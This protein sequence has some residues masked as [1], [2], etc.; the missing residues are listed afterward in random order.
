MPV[1]P[2]LAALLLA[3]PVVLHAQQPRL[4]RLIERG[5]HPAIRWGDFSEVQSEARTLYRDNGWQPLWVARGRPTRSARALLDALTTAGDRGLRPEDYDASQLTAL[6]ATLERG[7]ADAEQE[8]RFDAALSI[9]TLRL[10]RA[11]ALGRIPPREAN[12]R[13]STP[14]KPLDAVAT[15]REL[16]GSLDAGPILTALEPAWPQYLELKRAL[17]RYRALVRDSLSWR[18]PRPPTSGLREG[19][20]YAGA[21][22]LRRLLAALG[23]LAPEAAAPRGNDSTFSSE[24]ADG[25]RRFQVRQGG[26]AHV[27]GLLHEASWRLLSSQFSRRIRQMELALERWRWLPRELAAA[28]VPLLVNL[29]A[30]RLHYGAPAAEWLPVSMRV[31]LGSGFES[32][33]PVHAEILSTLLL[34]PP[35]RALGAVLFPTSGSPRLYLHGSTPAESYEEAAGCIRVA[36]AELLTAILLRGRADWPLERIRAALAGS[37]AMFVRLRQRVVVLVVYGTAVARENGQVFF[38]EDRFGLDRRLE[39]QLTRGYPYQ[40]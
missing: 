18:L 32:A 35:D 6:A 20:R 17:S 27:D 21:A 13:F 3:V 38:S 26:G 33:Q 12:V 16:R 4:Q 2:I 28:G 5:R 39:Q 22:R 11:L 1:R 24:L 23:D 25:V 40:Q 34:R 10:V 31:S 14:R 37:K 30:M 7:G 8:V 9:G 29:P 15:V 19:D 36:D